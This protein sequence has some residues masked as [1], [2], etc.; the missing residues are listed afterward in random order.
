MAD[1]RKNVPGKK[2]GNFS[3]GASVGAAGQ[4]MGGASGDT[5]IVGMQSGK[6]ADTERQGFDDTGYIDKQGTPYGEAAKFNFL[7]PGMDI[8]NQENAEI[9]NMSMKTLVGMSYPGDGYGSQ[10]DVQE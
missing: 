4:P 8:S 9:H 5:S 1:S 6:G 7:P 3:G 10:K 2:T